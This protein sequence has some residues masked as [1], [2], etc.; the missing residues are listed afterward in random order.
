[1]SSKPH[2]CLDRR[3]AGILLHITSLPGDDANGDLG[4]E[5]Y[6]FVDF[7]AAS[8]FSVWQTLPVVPAAADGS[9]YQSSSA[10]AGD[11]RLISI[12]SLAEQGWIDPR[13][14]PCA[15]VGESN[16]CDALRWANVGFNRY[17]DEADKAA[18]AE[19]CQT[20]AYWLDDYVL[21]QALHEEQIDPWWEWPSRLRQRKPQALAEA[22]ARLS[23]RLEELQFEQ[24]VF[25]RQWRQLHDY[26]RSKGIR[27]FGDIPIF[28]AHNSAEVWAHPEYFLLDEEGHTTVVAGVPPDY[29]SDLGQ[30]WGNPLYRWDVMHADGFAFWVDRMR[31]QLQLFDLVRIDHFRG[32]EACWEIPATEPNAI[33][34]NWT[35]GPGDALFDRLRE[36]F[37]DLPLVAEDLGVITDEVR[38]LRDRQA[39]PGMKILQFAFSGGP[40][41]PYLLF[42]HPKNSVVYTGTHD[43]DT[44]LSWYQGL[45][46]EDRA[47]V[48]D[49]LGRSRDPMPW[50]LIH[51]ALISPADLAVVPMQDVLGLDGAHRM[52]LPGTTTGN[53]KWRFDWNQVPK[54]LSEHL[55]QL[56]YMSGRLP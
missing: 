24:F 26:A 44:T 49:Y 18:L 35:Q 8:G 15:M 52:N 7:L 13:D 39:M 48:D 56:V 50:P 55:R 19:F 16:R 17:A 31:T 23:A 38:D 9:P 25:F 43:N 42:N 34:G 27:L 46:D 36:E 22:R 6:H 5:A 21:F 54:D 51:W 33:N 40:D 1:M 14:V 12:A 29:F 28:V 4:I 3:R 30:R 32:F 11:S 53:W 20:N 41:N 2:S 45:N 47:H 37:G 10:H